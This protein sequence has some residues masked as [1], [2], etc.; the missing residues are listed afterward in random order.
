MADIYPY[1]E[2]GYLLVDA[3]YLGF[4]AAQERVYRV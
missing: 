2:T 3:P 4:R 1:G